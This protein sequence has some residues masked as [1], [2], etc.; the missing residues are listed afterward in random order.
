MLGINIAILLP[1]VLSQVHKKTELEARVIKQRR[2]LLSW[3]P[4]SE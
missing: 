1:T 3:L 4:K 2:L